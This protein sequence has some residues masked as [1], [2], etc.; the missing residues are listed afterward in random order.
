MR[1]FV[2]HPRG[3]DFRLVRPKCFPNMLFMNVSNLEGLHH[4]RGAISSGSIPFLPGTRNTWVPHRPKYDMC[5]IIRRIWKRTGL[6][7]TFDDNG[8]HVRFSFRAP[9]RAFLRRGFSRRFRTSE[10]SSHIRALS[11]ATVERARRVLNCLLFILFV[12]AQNVEFYR[13]FVFFSLLYEA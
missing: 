7:S 2:S 4:T 12:F 9:I 6:E 1:A 13:A 10:N 5:R 3:I 8:R 11:N